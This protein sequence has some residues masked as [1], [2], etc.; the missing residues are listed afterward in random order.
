M[1]KAKP[2]STANTPNDLKLNRQTGDD[3][4]ED[5][6]VPMLTDGPEYP[7]GAAPKDPN[8]HKGYDTINEID[9]AVVDKL[10]ELDRTDPIDPE[11]VF[12]DI[13]NA[14]SMPEHPHGLEAA[15]AS[16]DPGPTG[17]DFEAAMKLEGEQ[18]DLTGV[19]MISSSG[20]EKTYRWSRD[21]VL[22]PEDTLEP[23]TNPYIL[24]SHIVL[25]DLNRAA[26]EARR[27]IAALD[28]EIADLD[29][30]ADEQIALIN[31][32]R[33][34]NK[35]QREKRKEDLMKIVAADAMVNGQP[36]EQGE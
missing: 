8:W 3:I 16:V 4:V 2:L 13:M 7:P 36:Q 14:S 27:T 17:L 33:D 19:H 20:E 34:A 9:P 26:V 21:G 22:N 28:R 30:T 12:D 18:P 31:A 6:G 15:L 11:Q 5:H 29:R 10:A 23:T 35:A 25:T 32:R 24:E 1:T